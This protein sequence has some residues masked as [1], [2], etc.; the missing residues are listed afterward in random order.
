MKHKNIH[1]HIHIHIHTNLRRQ[2]QS[3]SSP[4]CQI[5]KWAQDT[6]AMCRFFVLLW[7]CHYV[8]CCCFYAYEYYCRYW[9]CAGEVG[10]LCS[11]RPADE[12]SKRWAPA[13]AARRARRGRSAK[14]KFTDRRSEAFVFGQ[15]VIVGRCGFVDVCAISLDKHGLRRGV[16]HQ[17]REM[18]SLNH[19]VAPLSVIAAVGV[20]TRAGSG[21]ICMRSL[22]I[23]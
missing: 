12:A 23:N 4:P 7:S 21:R 8:F 6:R 15:V 22:T 19:S 1:I 11:A 5:A 17:R 13:T 10:A 18:T 14:P 9:Y 2:S 3:H 20:P 16:Q